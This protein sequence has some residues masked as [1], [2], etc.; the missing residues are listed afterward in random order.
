MSIQDSTT[1]E[2]TEE[3]QTTQLQC[4][5]ISLSE[6]IAWILVSILTVLFIRLLSVNVIVL[7]FYKKR[8]ERA[9]E[10]RESKYAMEGNP[11]YE[12]TDL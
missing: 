9:T 10:G 6:L 3:Q 8:Q 4:S 11:Y 12:A 2:T 1:E 7:W 5:V